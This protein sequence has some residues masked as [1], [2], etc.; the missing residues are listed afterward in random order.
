MSNLF[1]NPTVSGNLK[2]FGLYANS[3]TV[4]DVV[5]N[6]EHSDYGIDGFEVGRVRFK[7]L[8]YGGHS[9][10]PQ[11]SFYAYP[12]EVGVMEY[13]LIGETVM[14]QK[15]QGVHFYSRRVNINKTLQL[16]GF[17]N[18][19]NR[20]KAAKTQQNKTVQSQQ[21][22]EGSLNQ[23]DGGVPE[24]NLTNDNYVPKL[25][26]KNLKSFD[27]DIL[28]QNRYGSTIRLGS[29]QMQDAFNQNTI[30]NEKTGT[31]VLGPT[32]SGK[33]DAILIMRVGQKQN[34]N[35]TKDTPYALTVEDVN[36]DSSC[37]VMAEN[38]DIN[39]YFSSNFFTLEE[40]GIIDYTQTIDDRTGNSKT[41]LS[42]NQAIL[43]SGRIVLNSKEND[44]I[45]SSERDT[46]FGSNRNMVVDVGNDIYLNPVSSLGG[47]IFLGTV[48]KKNSVAKYNELESVLYE[49]LD[50]IEELAR[51]IVIP[52]KP[53]SEIT[54]GRITPTKL[55]VRDIK[56]KLVKIRD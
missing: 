16:N 12:I 47:Q 49:I 10:T 17:P 23:T 20:S 54:L 31:T 2:S 42:E 4:I 34:S 39:F 43:N 15:I 25:N 11:N 33:N 3:A 40:L 6:E 45:L 22:R 13:P 35:T 48:E 52:Y 27:G 29:S 44:V 24:E 56:S 51:T 19:V 8:D 41:V 55:S 30:V 5:I 14:V 37:F 21:A 28:I 18:I 9:T 1:W 32:N 26:V 53:L 36:L 38:Q 7:Y 46:I 50:H